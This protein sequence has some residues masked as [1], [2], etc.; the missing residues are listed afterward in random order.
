MH[1]SNDLHDLQSNWPKIHGSRHPV[2]V[3]LRHRRAI[4][5][6]PRLHPDTCRTKTSREWMN[7]F[8]RTK[9]RAIKTCDEI[10]T[11]TYNAF[12]TENPP[13]QPDWRT[14]LLGITVFSQKS[15]L[16]WA[17]PLN[18]TFFRVPWPKATIHAL[19]LKTER[20][21]KQL[22]AGRTEFHRKIWYI[23]L[24]PSVGEEIASGHRRVETEWKITHGRHV[25]ICIR[26]TGIQFDLTS[27]NISSTLHDFGLMLHLSTNKGKVGESM[28]NSLVVGKCND[29]WRVPGRWSNDW[30]GHCMIYFQNKPICSIHWNPLWWR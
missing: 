6:I 20:R 10:T 15:I 5:A 28:M 2:H 22:F 12:D 11:P 16:E 1:Y 17:R 23:S 3:R 4:S 18:N 14:E 9:K 7:Y 8:L 25:R 26:C 13:L 19:Y 24:P 27:I 29:A 30:W 21:R